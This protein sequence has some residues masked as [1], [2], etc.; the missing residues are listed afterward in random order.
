[1]IGSL[2]T[3][4]LLFAV[5]LLTG[6]LIACGADSRDEEA[7]VTSQTQPPD[8][9][10]TIN[11]GNKFPWSAII[12]APRDIQDLVNRYDAVVVG[13]ISA[14]SDTVR[15]LA[16]GKTEDDYKFLV[17]Q[18]L[19]LPTISRTFYDIQLEDVLLDDGNVRA[20][21]R[22]RLSH[23]HSAI[24]PQTGER[25]LFALISSQSGKSYGVIA[26]WALIHLDGGPIR[27]FDGVL[28]DY[29]GVTNEA[30]LKAAVRSAVPARVKLPFEEWPERVWGN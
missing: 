16:D 7:P 5:F 24:R 3:F 2:K 26:D 11:S 9:S 19:P 28:P 17:E 1:M 13:T 8:A 29:A 21:S 20:N 23:G 27:N 4:T 6:G 10:R 15:E 14:I 18:G 12:A 30:S 25:F 22:L